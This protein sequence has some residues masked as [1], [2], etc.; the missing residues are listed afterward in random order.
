MNSFSFAV[1]MLVVAGIIYSSKV[2]AS[3]VKI[4]ADEKLLETRNISLNTYAGKEFDYK[5]ME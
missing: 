2:N 5:Y 3:E 4:G 1:V